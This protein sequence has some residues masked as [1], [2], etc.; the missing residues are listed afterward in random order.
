LV[1][2]ADDQKIDFGAGLANWWARTNGESNEDL[3]CR[4]TKS[5][6]ARHSKKNDGDTLRPSGINVDFHGNLP[7]AGY[8]IAFLLEAPGVSTIGAPRHPESPRA[9][10]TSGRDAPAVLQV[11]EG[12]ELIELR[13]EFVPGQRKISER[14]GLWNSPSAASLRFP[15]A[16]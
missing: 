15:H 11:I 6:S 14:G 10:R 2:R 4:R 7:A 9:R 3:V 13:D 8:F 5:S 1:T 12:I 16:G